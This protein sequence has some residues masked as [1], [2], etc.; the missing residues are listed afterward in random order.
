MRYAQAVAQRSITLFI[1]HN[2]I[3]ATNGSQLQ[4]PIGPIVVDIIFQMINPSAAQ[5]ALFTTHSICGELRV[6]RVDKRLS[7]Q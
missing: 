2:P 6:R 1:R 3:T 7:L 5:I 4:E